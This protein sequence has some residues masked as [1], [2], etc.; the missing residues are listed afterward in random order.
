MVTA[1]ND[2]KSNQLDYSLLKKVLPLVTPLFITLLFPSLL[3]MT[4]GYE[5]PSEEEQR[6][7]LDIF[8]TPVIL[9]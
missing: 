4:L 3:T 6:V 2:W 8:Q 7:C 1:W 5:G 9:F